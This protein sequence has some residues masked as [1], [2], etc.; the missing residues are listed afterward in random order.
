MRR[1]RGTLASG[2][3][4][5]RREKR[6]REEKVIQRNRQRSREKERERERWEV[7]RALLKGNIVNVHRRCSSWLQ[8]R[9][10]PVSTPR[11]G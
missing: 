7:G 4:S 5:R 2:D 8:L 9:I 10:Y 1:G 11:S 6:Q 3:S